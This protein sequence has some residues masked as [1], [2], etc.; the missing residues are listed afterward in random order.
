VTC[1]TVDSVGA[2]ELVLATSDGADVVPGA[3]GEGDEAG[4]DAAEVAGAD[5]AGGVAGTDGTTG[6]VEF[7]GGMGADPEGIGNTGAVGTVLDFPGAVLKLPGAVPIGTV[8]GYVLLSAGLDL[9][10]EGTEA[11]LDCCWPGV[12]SN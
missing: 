10:S 3:E 8:A 11:E 4:T 2:G 5:G 9:D 12:Q 6:T 7:L 1:S